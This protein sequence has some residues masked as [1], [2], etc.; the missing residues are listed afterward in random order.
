MSALAGL[1]LLVVEDDNDLRQTLV[2]VV[3]SSGGRA[4]QAPGGR[5]AWALLEARRFDLVITDIRMA[6]GD[7]LELLR[8]VRE[9]PGEPVPVLLISGHADL[10][11]DEALT[12]GAAGL[13][14]KPFGM[15]ALIS[16]IQQALGRGR[17]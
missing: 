8:R 15:E 3:E 6:E 14:A 7:G 2:E 1:E 13:L 11:H 9:R 16:G 17:S 10:K 4:V 12:R 5:A